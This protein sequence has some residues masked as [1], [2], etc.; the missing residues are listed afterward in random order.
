MDRGASSVGGGGKSTRAPLARQRTGMHDDAP[1]PSASSVR[2]TRSRSGAGADG[3][4]AADP[5]GASS[6]ASRSHC[7]ATVCTGAACLYMCECVCACVCR[8]LMHA[9]CVSCGGHVQQALE[10]AS[11]RDR[12]TLLR[13]NTCQYGSS[14]PKRV[15]VT[16]AAKCSSNAS[17]SAMTAGVSVKSN[18][19]MFSRRRSGFDDLGSGTYPAPHTVARHAAAQVVHLTSPHLNLTPPHLTP[20]QAQPTSTS[21]SQRRHV[22]SPFWMDQRSS[23]CAGDLPTRAATSTSFASVIRFARRRGQ[24]AST[25]MPR[26]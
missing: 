13:C 5:S 25:T 16:D 11:D 4:A 7:A 22:Y 8:G 20:P 18:S 6:G 23:T 9:S 14:W 1:M 12:S 10:A 26:D 19:E 2:V 17:S 15:L 3:S 21:A 24:N